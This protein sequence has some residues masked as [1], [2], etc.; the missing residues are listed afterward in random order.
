MLRKNK[1]NLTPIPYETY[2][3]LRAFKYVINNKH[4]D[5]FWKPMCYK[6]SKR[7]KFCMWSGGQEEW[8]DYAHSLNLKEGIHYV[9]GV[10][11]SFRGPYPT[12]KLY[13]E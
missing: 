2:R 6:D 7:V 5:D 11:N 3:K 1:Y 8:L 4:T 12:I 9:H 10:S 13:I